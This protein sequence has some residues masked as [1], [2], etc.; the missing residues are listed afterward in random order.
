MTRV[1]L[2]FPV[3]T[4]RAAAALPGPLVCIRDGR[5]RLSPCRIHTLPL[6]HAGVAHGVRVGAAG[7]RAAPVRVGVRVVVV[8]APARGG[9]GSLAQFPDADVQQRV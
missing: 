7:A 5:V 6:L 3:V 1:S 8:R 4:P 9:K 2:I